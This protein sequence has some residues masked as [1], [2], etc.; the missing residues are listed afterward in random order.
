MARSE[1]ID[2]RREVQAVFQDP[3]GVY[4]P[5]YRV[6]HVF[7]TMIRQ[8]NLAKNRRES[9]EMAIDALETVGRSPPRFWANT[10]IS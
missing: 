6:D 8:F 1:W 5:F 7:D 2:F 9:R 3:F 4:N 10:P